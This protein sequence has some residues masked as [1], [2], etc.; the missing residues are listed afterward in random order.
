M[1]LLLKSQKVT[2][3][4]LIPIHDLQGLQFSLAELAV[5]SL[6]GQHFSLD[7]FSV[8]LSVLHFALV[9]ELLLV[10][11]IANTIETSLFES[12]S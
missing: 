5:D 6:V 3:G 11:I 7:A 1:H 12:P 9:L 10:E 4:K 2:L 8:E